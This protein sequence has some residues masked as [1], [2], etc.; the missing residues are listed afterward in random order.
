M[1][2]YDR[3]ASWQTLVVDQTTATEPLGLGQVRRLDGSGVALV[4]AK[5]LARH[6]GVRMTMRYTHFGLK[7]Q[8]KAVQPAGD[9]TT[10]RGTRRDMPAYCLHFERRG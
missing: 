3:G 1:R 6:S 2:R 9:F 8:A 4:E 10:P 7:D 5:E